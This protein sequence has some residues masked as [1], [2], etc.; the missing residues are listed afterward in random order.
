MKTIDNIKDLRAQVK[1]WKLQDLTI[2][3]VPTMGNLHDGLLKEI[4]REFW[5]ITT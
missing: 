1:A 2:A 4:T 3:F 5:H